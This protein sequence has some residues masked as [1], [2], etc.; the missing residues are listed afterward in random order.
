MTRS[1]ARTEAVRKKQAARQT[2]KALRRIERVEILFIRDMFRLNETLSRNNTPNPIRP[3]SKLKLALY[4]FH[5]KS[6]NRNS[7][8]TKY[9]NVLHNIASER[10]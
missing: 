10:V 3:I 4:C 2:G 7:G 8:L 5:N 6:N 9:C 1:W